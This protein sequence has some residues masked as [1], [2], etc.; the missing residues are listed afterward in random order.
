MYSI[1]YIWKKQEV[2]VW[3]G[4]I[5]IDELIFQISLGSVALQAL[6]VKS[7]QNVRESETPKAKDYRWIIQNFIKM[8][9]LY[10]C[11]YLN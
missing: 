7:M 5:L 2:V 11:I 6:N 10:K 8:Y 3:R 4:N 1:H 9:F